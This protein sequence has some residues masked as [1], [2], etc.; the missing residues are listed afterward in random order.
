[1]IATKMSEKDIRRSIRDIR[2]I[3]K[4]IRDDEAELT[5]Y[6]FDRTGGYISILIEVVLETEE[7]KW[8]Q[9]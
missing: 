5:K 7:G 2:R 8:Q 6:T 1:M 9:K 4:A 3:V